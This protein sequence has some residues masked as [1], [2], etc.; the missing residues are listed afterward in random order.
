LLLLTLLNVSLLLFIEI[1]YDNLLGLD[2]VYRVEY[3]LCLKLLV[4]LLLYYPDKNLIPIIG[5][6]YEFFIYLFI[7]FFLLLLFILLIFDYNV[8]ENNN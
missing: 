5:Y 2:L 8:L 3:Q 7:K 1:I 6:V 4:N